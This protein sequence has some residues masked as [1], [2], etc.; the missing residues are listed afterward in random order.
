M[1]IYRLSQAEFR[2][3]RDHDARAELT[4]RV[5]TEHGITQIRAPSGRVLGTARQT[6]E[7]IP[8]ERAKFRAA[9][10]AVPPGECMCREWQK[11]AGQESD[12]HPI[13]ANKT[14][15]ESQ[16]LHD[17]D[18]P[19]ER[20]TVSATAAH[21]PQPEPADS[22]AP[23]APPPA[24]AEPSAHPV[25]APPPAAAEPSAP[26]VLAPS[27]VVAP[28]TL[29]VTRTVTTN[30]IPEP[31]ACVCHVWAGGNPEQHHPLCQFKSV[32]ELEHGGTKLEL[33]EL[34]TGAV[35]RE[36]TAEEAAASKRKETED[37]VGAIN[38]G[39]G[40]LYYVRAG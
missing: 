21:E 35:V 27:A 36:A 29:P 13:C 12:H 26:A 39:D 9:H 38:F 20:V 17:P 7:R 6:G 25:L 40:K 23:T 19:R 3:W 33:V 1:R 32:W 30:T 8:I 11:P 2:A 31:A 37:G 5:F 16:Q 18:A 10:H 15:W 34:E 4:K 22:T 24:P 28:A 14:A